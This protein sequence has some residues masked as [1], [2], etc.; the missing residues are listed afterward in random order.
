MEYLVDRYDS[1]H[2]ISFPKGTREWYAM[3]NWL[4]FQNAGVGPMQGQASKC[5]FF[6][7]LSVCFFAAVPR[8]CGSATHCN[9]DSLPLLRWC[10]S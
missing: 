1:E 2:K 10:R 3:K 7:F 4:Y 9:D 8:F 6:L 5:V